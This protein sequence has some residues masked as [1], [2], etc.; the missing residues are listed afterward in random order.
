MAE[1]QIST[2]KTIFIFLKKTEKKYFIV[3][4]RLNFIKE[5]M[6]FLYLNKRVNEWIYVK[7]N[8]L[9]DINFCLVNDKI[10]FRLYINKMIYEK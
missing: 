6:C 8:K 4:D 7:D 3:N 5:K 9:N 1:S 2:G 10:L